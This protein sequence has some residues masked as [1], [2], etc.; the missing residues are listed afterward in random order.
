VII[1]LLFAGGMDAPSLGDD[2][3]RAPVFRGDVIHA[4]RANLCH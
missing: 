1:T 3:R 4:L 2:Y